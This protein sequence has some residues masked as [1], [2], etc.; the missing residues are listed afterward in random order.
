[1]TV[2]DLVDIA[3]DKDINAAL[4]GLM[5]KDKDNAR[6]WNE[7]TGPPA[8]KRQ[9]QMLQ[10]LKQPQ[11]IKISGQP[12]DLLF[13]KPAAPQGPR[14]PGINPSVRPT[15]NREP[16]GNK[17]MSPE[18]FRPTGTPSQPTGGVQTKGG[19]YPTYSANSAEAQ[20]FRER[21]D[22]ARQKGETTFPWQGRMY[23][24]EKKGK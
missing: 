4:S 2:A 14:D 21:F 23:T 20:S 9:A 12:S 6:M 22:L 5:G 10:Q 11:P 24:N 8:D 16:P 17:P 15:V 13:N 3:N 19:F 1:M 7:D 18:S